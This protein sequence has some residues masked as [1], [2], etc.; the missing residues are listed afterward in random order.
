[1][2]NY[3]NHATWSFIGYKFVKKCHVIKR[4]DAEPLYLIYTENSARG[5]KVVNVARCCFDDV[6]QKPSPGLAFR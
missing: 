4:S 5:T 2:K 6:Q 1:M 3:R